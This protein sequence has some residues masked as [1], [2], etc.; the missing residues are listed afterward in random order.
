MDNEILK[1]CINLLNTTLG[2]MSAS[3]A[4]KIVK[5]RY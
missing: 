5:T 2:G 4:D 1:S 3:D